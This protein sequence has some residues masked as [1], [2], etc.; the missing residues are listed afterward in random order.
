[1]GLDQKLSRY[2]RTI[3][4][5]SFHKLLRLAS[6]AA[7]Q[8]RAAEVNANVFELRCYTRHSAVAVVNVI[9]VEIISLSSDLWF[10]IWFRFKLEVLKLEHWTFLWD[11]DSVLHD[12]IET[13]YQWCFKPMAINHLEFFFP[14]LSLSLCCMISIIFFSY[15]VP[16]FKNT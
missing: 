15:F 7:K 14:C 6:V 2:V 5:R 12:T 10:W 3:F 11:F 4:G 16:I 9:A 8:K 13:W 1:M